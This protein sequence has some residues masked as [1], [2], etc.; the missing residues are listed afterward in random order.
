MCACARAAIHAQDVLTLCGC[1]LL[2]DVHHQAGEHSDYGSLTLL[3][4]DDI[5]GLQV[6]H[7]ESEEFVDAIPIPDTGCVSLQ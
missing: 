6:F 2:L 3:F 7:K 4:Q 1:M 5:G